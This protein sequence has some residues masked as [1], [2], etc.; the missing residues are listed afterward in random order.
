VHKKKLYTPVLRIGAALALASALAIPAAA[1]TL[2]PLFVTGGTAAA[3]VYYDLANADLFPNSA[4][5]GATC[6]A[7]TEDCNVEQLYAA[8]GTGGAQASFLAHAVEGTVGSGEPPYNDAVNLP[9]VWNPSP[10]GDIDYAAGDAPLSVSDLNTYDSV[11]LSTGSTALQTYGNADVVPTMGVPVAIAYNASGTGLPS[12]QTLNLSTAALCG[13]FTGTVTMWNDPTIEAANPG[14]TF[15]AVPITVVVR[16]DGSG[17]TFITSNELDQICPTFASVTG[18]VGLGSGTTTTGTVAPIWGT[19][20][21]TF[22]Q[23]KGSGGVQGE[24]EATAGTIGYL[25]VNY[26]QP[27]AGSSAPLAAA[28]E[29]KHKQY[30]TPTVAASVLGM[31]GPFLTTGPTGTANGTTTAYPNP[32]TDQILYVGEP[33]QSGA[34]PIVGFTYAYFYQCSDAKTSTTALVGTHGYFKNYIYK[35]ESAGA[36]TPADTIIQDNGLVQLPNGIKSKSNDIIG[37]GSDKIVN[38]PVSGT[39]TVVAAS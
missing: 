6:T 30:E 34:Y 28:V 3:F 14:V 5:T 7:S 11:P 15:A 4:D 21:G 19:N 32:V 27:F 1:A 10:T 23:E 29:N 26:V 22:V 2:T 33:S 13:I 38:G 16:S 35:L 8:T 9:G 12:G 36:L 17:T 20:G 37:T 24:I 39:C 31:K 18:G 25:S